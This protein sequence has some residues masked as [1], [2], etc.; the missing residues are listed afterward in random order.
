MAAV[1]VGRAS[2]LA[3]EDSAEEWQS[4]LRSLQQLICAL[5][6]KNQQLRWALL[7]RKELESR[8]NEARNL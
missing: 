2:N 1:P 4:Q 5:L 3:A 7:E 8:E 6:I